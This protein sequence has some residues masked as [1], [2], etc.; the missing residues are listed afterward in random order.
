MPAAQSIPGI[1]PLI[2]TGLVAAI[3]TEEAF[4]RGRDFGAWLPLV[5]RQYSTD[6][7]S[8]LGR[9]SK[10]GSRY[11]RTLFVQAA[12]VIPYAP[13]LGSGSG[14]AYGSRTLRCATSAISSLPLWPTSWHG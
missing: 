7:K 5:P 9:I 10:R 1:G 6:G 14:S 13:T 2:S 11:L 4:A 8:I 12:H 3:G